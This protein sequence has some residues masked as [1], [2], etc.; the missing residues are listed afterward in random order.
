MPAGHPNIDSLLQAGTALP[1][2]HPSLDPY[3]CF[4]LSTAVVTECSVS[5]VPAHPSVDA[6]IQAGTPL[7]AG[8]VLTDPLLRSWMPAGHPNIDS[9]LQAGTALPLGH[10]SIDA[11]L[12][13]ATVCPLVPP[14]HPSTDAAIAAGSKLPFGHPKLDP[15]LRP[16]LPPGHGNCDE[17]M[18]AGTPLPIGHP[19]IDSYLCEESVFSAGIYMAFAMTSL[20]LLAVTAK[21]CAPLFGG[22]FASKDSTSNVDTPAV[23]GKYSRVKSGEFVPTNPPDV[24]ANQLPSISRDQPPPFNSNENLPRRSL[25]LR[26]MEIL[27]A[28][29]KGED[30]YAYGHNGN[31]KVVPEGS[32]LPVVA[33]RRVEVK[34]MQ[35]TFS[36]RFWTVTMDYRLPY[37]GWSLGNV[38]IF[39]L[40]L[41]LNVAC[42]LVAG[43]NNYGKC[44]WCVRMN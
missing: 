21:Q 24:E 3:L 7:P 27:H 8:H 42:L 9:L 1:L 15:L 18:A 22:Y 4:N 13:P 44:I 35:N 5:V 33:A 36:H 29:H 19:S 28:L 6:S 32:T 14:S 17:Y 23:I 25:Q 41:G 16:L 30:L 11:Y 37:W 39:M 12:C 10:P 26:N 31:C 2:G 40:Y 20:F 43:G 34:E 38:L